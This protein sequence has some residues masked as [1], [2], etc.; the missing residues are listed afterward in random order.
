[1]ARQRKL[2]RIYSIV[3][4]IDPVIRTSESFV[5]WTGRHLGRTVFGMDFNL[6]TV[7]YALEVIDRVNDAKDPESEKRALKPQ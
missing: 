2:F 1:M 4:L 6:G 3:L 5:Q 7:R